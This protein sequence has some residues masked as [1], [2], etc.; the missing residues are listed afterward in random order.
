MRD[1][2]NFDA[3]Q[4]MRRLVRCR[5]CVGWCVR[6]RKATN[7][8][9]SFG[10]SRWRRRHQGVAARCHVARRAITRA[11]RSSHCRDPS[12]CRCPSGADRRWSDHF[13]RPTTI[14]QSS[15]VFSQSSVATAHGG[16]CRRSTASGR[17]H[18]SDGFS[19]CRETRNVNIAKCRCRETHPLPCYH[20]KRLKAGH[21]YCGICSGMRRR[22]MLPG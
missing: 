4:S 12:S 21:R 1:W 14:G 16:R 15:R 18:T 8:A 5:K 7:D 20:R 10:W 9:T 3:G 6:W 19:L 17:Q 2:S 13:C 22:G 11:A